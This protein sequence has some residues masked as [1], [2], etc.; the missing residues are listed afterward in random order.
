MRALRKAQ[1]RSLRWAIG[2]RN[3]PLYLFLASWKYLFSLLIPFVLISLALDKYASSMYFRYAYSF[4]YLA[5]FALAV[6]V[7]LP[8]WQKSL[9]YI[10][11]WPDKD[12]SAP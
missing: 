7:A 1:Y 6:I 11:R 5:M 9:K 4:Q 10:R 3:K 12:S 2:R 8:R